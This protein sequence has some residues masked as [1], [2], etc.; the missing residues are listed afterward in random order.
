LNGDGSQQAFYQLSTGTKTYKPL[1]AWDIA[2]ETQ[3]ITY[4]IWVNEALGDRVYV[5]PN[6][7][8][9]NWS[10]VDTFGINNWQ[11]LHNSTSVWSV[12]AFDQNSTDVF[13]VG[14]GWY[15]GPP[16]HFVIGDSINIV[17]MA[18]GQVKKLWIENL[19]NKVYH[20]RYANLDGS[21]EVVDSLQKLNYGARNFGY[22]SF[23]SSK[24]VDQEPI[25]NKWDLLFTKSLT[26]DS[27]APATY[28]S[29]FGSVYLNHF[30]YVTKVQGID[31]TNILY[32]Q[33]SPIDSNI[34][35]IGIDYKQDQ[36]GVWAP[37]DS[38][39][40]VIADRNGSLFELQFTEVDSATGKIV[41]NKTP[42]I[43]AT[44]I[45]EATNNGVGLALYP[46]PVSDRLSIVATTTTVGNAEI[47]ISDLAG[48]QAMVLDEATANGVNHW[49]VPVNNLAAGLWL[50]SVKTAT[51][52][53]TSK[54][55][56]TN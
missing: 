5:Y 27:V 20:F 46:N 44:G 40:Y 47:V 34:T 24:V 35:I 50:V 15:T 48:R 53:V 13:D 8:T 21:G 54:F 11:A 4:G 17:V 23:D 29:V 38:L 36:S 16:D 52:V 55:V 49:D 25:H 51:G 19:E 22:Y 7:D 32:N 18:N 56:K 6:G 14:W 41:F 12:G 43:A 3:G 30:V 31:V 10:T 9:S 33:F 45:A 26:A 28:H 2:F 37:K 39:A 42:L 1:N